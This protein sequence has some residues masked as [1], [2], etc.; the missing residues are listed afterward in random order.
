MKKVYYTLLQ[1]DHE[2][3]KW[4][5]VFGGYDL[6][7]VEEEQSTLEGYSTRLPS[8]KIIRSGDRQ[9]EIEAEVEWFNECWNRNYINR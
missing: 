7:E 3:K 9:K 5:I 8:F 4:L 2:L 6:E 1:F